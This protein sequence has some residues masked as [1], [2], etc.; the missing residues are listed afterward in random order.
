MTCRG[1]YY[2]PPEYRIV[3]S[4]RDRKPSADTI[5]YFTSEQLKMDY[6]FRTLSLAAKAA[7]KPVSG[8]PGIAW[9]PIR[10]LFIRMLLSG[11]SL[12][13]MTLAWALCASQPQSRLSAEIARR[14]WS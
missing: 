13:G 2:L 14:E 5:I 7:G 1:V 3:A 10:I 4:R 9:N 12:G 11:L 6:V 8:R